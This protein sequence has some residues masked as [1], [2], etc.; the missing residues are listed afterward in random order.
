VRTAAVREAR[1]ETGLEV[2]IDGLVNIYSYAGRA[3]III[4]YAATL[5]GGCLS[6]DDEG[7]EA[8]FFSPNEL[9]WDALAFRSTHEALREFLHKEIDRR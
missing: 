8:A 1:E 4:V 3:P 9:P 5:L 2:R 7:L 6:C